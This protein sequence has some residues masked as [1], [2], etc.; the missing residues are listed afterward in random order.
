MGCESSQMVSEI[1]PSPVEN[2]VVRIEQ[3]ITSSKSIGNTKLEEV[4]KIGDQFFQE[5]KYVEAI[6]VYQ[7]M[8]EEGYSVD[9]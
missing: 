6:R 5:K 3:M 9:F 2:E 8:I 4:E 7:K 1:Q